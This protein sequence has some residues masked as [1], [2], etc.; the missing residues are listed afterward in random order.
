MTIP[1]RGSIEQLQQIFQIQAD[2]NRL[3]TAVDIAS[4][5]S[6][7]AEVEFV[8]ILEDD[9]ASPEQLEAGRQKVVSLFEA[10]LDAVLASR[11]HRINSIRDIE[12]LMRGAK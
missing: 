6:D 4:K 10:Y 9:G 7:L 8:Q 2:G 11:T 1:I 12:N 3:K 5:K